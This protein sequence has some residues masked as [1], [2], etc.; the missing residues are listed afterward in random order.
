MLFSGPRA[1][2]RSTQT[3]ALHRRATRRSTFSHPD[4]TVG[5][6]ISPDLRLLAA[7]AGF[8]RR[9]GLAAVLLTL[10]RRLRYAVVEVTL[11]IVAVLKAA[12]KGECTGDYPDL[13]PPPPGPPPP[14]PY[15]GRGGGKAA[16]GGLG[17]G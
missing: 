1:R 9:S 6:G 17:E 11:L 15:K 5:S 2:A 14:L 16:A 10:P 12:V 13:S 8:H 7:L 4:F 3:R